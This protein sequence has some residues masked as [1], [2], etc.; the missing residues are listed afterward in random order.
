[1][2]SG[3]ALASLV[4]LHLRLMGLILWPLTAKPFNPYHKTDFIVLSDTGGIVSISGWRVV[5][6][7]GGNRTPSSYA[8]PHISVD[9]DPV[10]WL[11][12]SSLARCLDNPARPRK[13][14]KA[15]RTR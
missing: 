5:I 8:C 6:L 10:A 2:V 3:E 11:G 12:S 9:L 4:Y 1:M 7:G 15:T 14:G 13:N